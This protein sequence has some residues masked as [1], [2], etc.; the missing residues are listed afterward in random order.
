MGNLTISKKALI[1]AMVALV[2]FILSPD[3]YNILPENWAHIIAG[4]AAISGVL[5]PQLFK[6]KP[7]T[8]VAEEK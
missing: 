4:T 2:S 1:P 3:F 7:V 5:F 6:K 8:D